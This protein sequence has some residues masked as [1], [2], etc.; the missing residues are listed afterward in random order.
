[1]KV[2][3]G[4]TPNEASTISTAAKLSLWR[5]MPVGTSYGENMCINPNDR[6]SEYHCKPIE[7]PSP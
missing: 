2:I 1:M 7:D 3:P 4:G 6:N 5:P